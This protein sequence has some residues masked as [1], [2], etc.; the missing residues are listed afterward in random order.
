MYEFLR[1]GMML[2]DG[3]RGDNVSG[4]NAKRGVDI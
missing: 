4:V 2:N 1:I 3:G